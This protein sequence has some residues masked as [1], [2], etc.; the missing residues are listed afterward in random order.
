MQ[1]K[2]LIPKRYRA[3]NALQISQLT[4]LIE[5]ESKINTKSFL[6]PK[7][8]K[9]LDIIPSKSDSNKWSPKIELDQDTQQEQKK[10]PP[11]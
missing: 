9:A 1:Q 4:G 5:F 7:L 10:S 11:S 2:Q 6:R 8:H 3:P